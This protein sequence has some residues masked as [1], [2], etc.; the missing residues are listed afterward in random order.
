MI[1]NSQKM[2]CDARSDAYSER[3][4]SQILFGKNDRA[5]GDKLAK[6]TMIIKQ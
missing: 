4:Y 2:Q 6:R 1:I 3:L 5:Y